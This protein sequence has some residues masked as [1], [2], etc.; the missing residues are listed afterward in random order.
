MRLRCDP[1]GR[2]L[3]N[4][5]ANKSFVIVRKFEDVE[6]SRKSGS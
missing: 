5:A 1:A 6:T 3:N 2:V 4:D